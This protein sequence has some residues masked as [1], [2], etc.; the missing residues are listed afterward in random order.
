MMT[1]LIIYLNCFS[2]RFSGTKHSFD[3]N[4]FGTLIDLEALVDDTLA[5]TYSS[6]PGFSTDLI[7]DSTYSHLEN[8][9]LSNLNTE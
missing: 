3:R 5:S 1:Q 6:S 7:V 9:C 8:E 4:S 2:A